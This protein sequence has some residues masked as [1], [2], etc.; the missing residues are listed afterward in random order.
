MYQAVAQGRAVA[1]AQD[2]N[3]VQVLVRLGQLGEMVV[4]V[5]VAL[6]ADAEIEVDV[7]R[8]RLLQCPFDDRLDRR[9]ARAAG[10]GN[11]RP[12]MG[13]AQ[14]GRAER[15]FDPDA[16]AEFELLG[17]MRAGGAARGAAHVEFE[18]RVAG[19]VGHG[20]VARRTALESD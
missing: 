2:R 15:P 4:Q 8:Q 5:E 1:F 19:H 14:V 16:I 20:I 18:H 3:E 6:A 9:H 17:D 12:A 11:D 13:F 10:H 7:L